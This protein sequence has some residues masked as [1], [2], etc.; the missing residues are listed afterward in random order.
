MQK[1]KLPPLRRDHISEQPMKAYICTDRS[2]DS[3]YSVVIFAE[4]RGKAIANA[5]FTG[6]FD[7][8][9]YHFTDIRAT[10]VPALDKHYRGSMEMDWYNDADRAAMVKELGYHCSYEYDPMPS[11]C[12]RCSANKWC[13]RYEEVTH[14]E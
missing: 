6:Y 4:T 14:G 7:D 11:E 5:L 2:F 8:Y 3:G 10:R 12:E 9:D 1:T 13:S